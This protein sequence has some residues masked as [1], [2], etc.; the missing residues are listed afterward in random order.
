MLPRNCVQLISTRRLVKVASVRST[1]AE[2][3]ITWTSIVG[4][5]DQGPTRL[6]S[7][8]IAVTRSGTRSVRSGDQRRRLG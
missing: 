7:A 8:S 4:G 1:T 3:K 6:V 2:P 5:T